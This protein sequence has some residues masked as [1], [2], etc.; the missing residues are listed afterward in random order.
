[1]GP[2]G[3]PGGG[4]GPVGGGEGEGDREGEGEGEALTMITPLNCPMV[5]GHGRLIPLIKATLKSNCL[6]FNSFVL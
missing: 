2:G 5:K 4:G 3:G 1:M 6:F